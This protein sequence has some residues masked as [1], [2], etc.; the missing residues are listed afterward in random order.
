MNA[1]RFPLALLGGAVLAALVAVAVLAPLIA[2]YDA[3]ALA[4]DSLEQPSARHLLGTNNI[5]QDI[6]SQ[7]I[8]GTRAS[9]AV[10][11]GAASLAVAL[12]VLV[13][14]G[15]GLVGGLADVVAMRVVDVFLAVP[16]LPLLV[17]VAALVGA[18]RESVIL[19]IALI[20]WPVAARVLRSQTLTLRT[21]G[22]V[23][24]VSGFGGGPFYVMR[25][26][27]VPN[28]GPILVAEFVAIASKAVL[29]EASLAFLGLA[30]PTAVSW[31]LMLN[32]AVF[33]PGL[34]FTP[35]WTWWVLPPGFAIAL[36][37][38][39]FALL[40][41]GLEPLMNPRWRRGL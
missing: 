12:G 37:V 6:F 29:L 19:L 21:R 20:T 5:G 40:A 3:R 27:L 35:L 9:L 38:L 22:F 16:R 17:L 13:G 2:P 28:L 39:G 1:L 24:A 25:R 31:G 34:Y 36:A 23:R 32:R 11:V 18:G 30:D 33:Q 8:W 10:A 15:A 4:G 7:V 14:I 26:H 41:V